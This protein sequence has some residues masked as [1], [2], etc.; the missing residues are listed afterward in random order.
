ME[1]KKTKK[2][3]GDGKLKKLHTMLLVMQEEYNA[4]CREALEK[5]LHNDERQSKLRQS[6]LE[7]ETE[8]NKIKKNK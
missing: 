7:I 5:P 8:I 2:K 3:T 6:M 1:K 4:L